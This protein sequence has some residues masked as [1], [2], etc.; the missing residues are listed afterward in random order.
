[1]DREIAEDIEDIGDEKNIDQG[2]D[3]SHA[4]AEPLVET[5]EQQ[6]H[7]VR[8]FILVVIVDLAMDDMPRDFESAQD[9][10]END[11]RSYESEDN[12]V[13]EPE[14]LENWRNQVTERNGEYR[15]SDET[16]ER[17][18]RTNG[19]LIIANHT[20]EAHQQQC[21][22]PQDHGQQ[23]KNGTAEMQRANTRRRILTVNQCWQE[24]MDEGV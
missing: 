12:G 7:G 16:D 8:T 3:N 1:M 10:D 22:N 14:N 15:G 24:S 19:S 4:D 2:V 6:S 23:L 21:N 20:D 11:Q 17:S 13:F 5:F 9:D 18:G